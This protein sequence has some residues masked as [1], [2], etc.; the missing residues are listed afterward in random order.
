M[1]TYPGITGRPRA[2]RRAWILF[3]FLVLSLAPSP[4]A[5]QPVSPP[6][7]RATP[8]AGPLFADSFGLGK[9]WQFV[10]TGLSDRRRMIQFATIGLCIGLYI[11]MRKI[12]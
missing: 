7:Q 4:A 5:A 12:W 1:V 10:E 6:R 3:L 2:C 8:V 9:A 11:M